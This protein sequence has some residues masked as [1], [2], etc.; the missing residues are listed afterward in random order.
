MAFFILFPPVGYW[1]PRF[2]YVTGLGAGFKL[3]V[4]TAAPP[5]F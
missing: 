5:R 1:L 4:S 3:I 2:Q